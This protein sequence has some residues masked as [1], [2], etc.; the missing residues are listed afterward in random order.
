MVASLL[1]KQP[2]IAFRGR[3]SAGLLGRDV[4]AAGAMARSFALAAGF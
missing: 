3:G 1:G 2:S 4:L